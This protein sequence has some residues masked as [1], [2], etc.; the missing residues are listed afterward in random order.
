MATGREKHL[1]ALNL[2][3][4]GGQI[5]NLPRQVFVETPV[6]IDAN[7]PRP[8]PV[9]LPTEVLP[10]CTRTAAVTDM[11]VRAALERSRKKLREALELDPTVTDKKAGWQALEACL[12][13]HADLLPRFA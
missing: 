6:I 3:N 12:T 2:S 8:Q 10:Y 9:T 13:A 5:P 1:S 11:I 7:G 4:A